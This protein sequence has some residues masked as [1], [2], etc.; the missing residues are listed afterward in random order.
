MPID[1]IGNNALVPNRLTYVAVVFNGS[2]ANLKLYIDGL[3]DKEFNT[4]QSYFSP[5]GNFPYTLIATSSTT[6]TP[7]GFSGMID[8]LRVSNID[9]NIVPCSQT[10]TKAK[11]WGEIKA[12][13]R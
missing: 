2:S 8:E 13:Y 10:P 3:L 12:I 5:E 11:T 7:A 9:R 6:S 4:S 1:Y